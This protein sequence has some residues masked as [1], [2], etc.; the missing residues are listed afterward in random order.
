MHPVIVPSS[1]STQVDSI[2]VSNVNDGKMAYFLP[3][4]FDT[5]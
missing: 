2:H 5:L 3:V 1:D 4:G